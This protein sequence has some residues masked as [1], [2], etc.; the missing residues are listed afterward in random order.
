[1]S[2]RKTR[3]SSALNLR[4]GPLQVARLGPDLLLGRVQK[5]LKIIQ[6]H[7]GSG[8]RSSIRDSTHAPTTP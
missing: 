6:A 1:M 7:F 3:F 8:K 5:L 2:M 4:R